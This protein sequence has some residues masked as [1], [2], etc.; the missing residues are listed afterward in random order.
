MKK[1]II[2][3]IILI[4]IIVG[5]WGIM[6]GLAWHKVAEAERQHRQAIEDTINS[7]HAEVT[8]NEATSDLFGDDGKV[9]I[10]FLGL[11]K[12]AGQTEGHCDAIQLITIDKKNNKITITAVPRGTYSPLPP[13]TGKLASDYYVSNACGLGGLEYGIDQI[14]KILGQK[15]DYL[16]TVGFSEVLGILRNLKL[17]TTE[18]LQWLRLRQGYAIGEPQR[19]RDHSTFLKYLLTT[20][21]PTETSQVDKVLQYIIYKTVQT[22]LTFAETQLIIEVL[23]KMDLVNHPEKIQL[24]MRPAFEVQDIAYIPTEL[25]AYLDRMLGGVK[26]ALSKEDY[27]DITVEEKQ[28]KLIEVIAEKKDDPEFIAWAFDNNFWLQIEDNETRLAIQFDFIKK[29]IEIDIAKDKREA[30]I[31]DYILEMENRGESEWLE[32]GRELLAKEIK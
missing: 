22:D 14:E 6:Q 27:A 18:T 21:V 2:I 11:D 1:L 26:W 12:R 9:S 31:L 16:V 3:S 19:A 28:A 5:A 30:V 24:A 29:Y 8:T 7:H 17:P 15:A 4:V 32:K 10:L 23:S 13:G 20:Y 25:N